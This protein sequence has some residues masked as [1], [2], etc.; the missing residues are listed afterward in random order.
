[1]PAG[2]DGVA[3]DDPHVAEPLAGKLAGHDQ[4][5]DALARHAQQLGRIGK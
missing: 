5:A 1:M 4:L 2:G 3:R